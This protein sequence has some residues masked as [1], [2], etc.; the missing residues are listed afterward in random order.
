MGGDGECWNIWVSGSYCVYIVK[1]T[2]L[3]ADRLIL[4]EIVRFE[5]TLDPS[6]PRLIG[7]RCVENTRSIIK[8]PKAR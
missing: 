8:I 5:L 1:P 4:S 3:S 6:G 7:S 2:L